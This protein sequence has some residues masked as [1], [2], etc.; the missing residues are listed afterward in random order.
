MARLHVE[1]GRAAREITQ[2]GRVAEEFGQR[3]VGVQ[4]TATLLERWQVQD[5][6]G[7]LPG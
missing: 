6:T 4:T 3:L 1:A 5:F 2:L 7:T